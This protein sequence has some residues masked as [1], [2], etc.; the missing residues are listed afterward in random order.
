MKYAPFLRNPVTGILIPDSADTTT[1]TCCPASTLKM[2]SS[3]KEKLLAVHMASPKSPRG[4]DDIT[5][6]S[7]DAPWNPSSVNVIVSP[8]CRSISAWKSRITPESAPAILR[9]KSRETLE[10]APT[11][12]GDSITYL[13]TLPAPASVETV[14]SVLFARMPDNG[15]RTPALDEITRST[16]SPGVMRSPFSTIR[17]RDRLG[18]R[19]VQAAL[20]LL[21]EFPKTVPTPTT[22][23]PEKLGRSTMI[24]SYSS[25]AV[26]KLKVKLK[27]VAWSAIGGIN[28]MVA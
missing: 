14:K 19:M 6:Q 11:A 25:S 28:A 13:L 3:C 22:S 2:M 8:A 23:P 5:M 20:N 12:M 4:I 15:R 24:L 7:R 9:V 27:F 17:F 18:Q 10:N 1:V 26:F 21:P 16:C